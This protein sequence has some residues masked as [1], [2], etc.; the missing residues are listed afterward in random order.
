[1]NRIVLSM[2]SDRQELEGLEQEVYDAVTLTV[3]L[4]MDEIEEHY[5][6]FMER[7]R[8]AGPRV[9]RPTR[10]RSGEELE[11]IIAH[12]EAF[13]PLNQENG[14]QPGDATPTE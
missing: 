10:A 4:A 7:R 1:M 8:A 12:M 2:L 9:A 13:Y 14:E 6:A 3:Q 11:R 5:A